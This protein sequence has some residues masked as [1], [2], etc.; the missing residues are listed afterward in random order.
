MLIRYDRVST[1]DQ[2][3]H[4]A[5]DALTDAGSSRIF[6]AP[7]SG[8]AVPRPAL[9]EVIQSADEGDALIVWELIASPGRCAN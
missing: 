2:N 7:V 4:V 6:S 3:S 5:T 8:T 1:T 9:L